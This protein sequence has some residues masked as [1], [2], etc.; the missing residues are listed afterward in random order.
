MLAAF[1]LTNRHL[2]SHLLLKLNLSKN[3]VKK[4]VLYI[5]EQI[6]FSVLAEAMIFNLTMTAIITIVA[7]LI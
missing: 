1:S 5:M 6:V 3:K 2:Y 4:E 7:I